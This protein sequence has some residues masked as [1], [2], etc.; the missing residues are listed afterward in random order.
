M[1]HRRALALVFWMA[2]GLGQSAAGW[3][4]M[5]VRGLAGLD[6][7]FGSGS[8]H[9]FPSG[10][11]LHT[12]HPSNLF[13]AGTRWGYW[14]EDGGRYC[15]QSPPDPLWRCYAVDRQGR[16]V[17]FFGEDGGV[18]TGEIVGGIR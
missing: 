1:R 18:V 4:A 5:P 16:I 14:R 9:F 2:S 13:A 3:E 12:P 11:T 15:A 6:L 17:R 10:R 8:Q 7:R